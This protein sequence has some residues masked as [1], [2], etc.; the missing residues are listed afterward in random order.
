M[1]SQPTPDPGADPTLAV[2]ER[3]LVQL[4]ELVEIAMTAA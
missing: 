3:Q 4:R 1:T 2:A